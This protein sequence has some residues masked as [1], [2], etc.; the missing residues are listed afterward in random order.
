MTPKLIQMMVWA[1]SNLSSFS[2]ASEALERL[3]GLSI[4]DRRIRRQVESVGSARIAEREAAVEKMKSMSLPARREGRPHEECPDVAVVMMDGGRYQRRDHFGDA[5]LDEASQTHWRE[6]KIGCFLSMTSKVHDQDPCPNIPSEFAQASAV[7]EIA[8]IAEKTSDSEDH[9]ITL[10]SQAESTTTYEPPELLSKDVVASGQCAE[11]FGFHLEARAYALNF[12]QAKRTAFVADGLRVN[13]SI[14]EKH[15]PDSVAIADIIHVLSYVWSAA[16]AAEQT[17]GYSRWSQWIWQGDVHKVISELHQLSETYSRPEKDT[18]ATDPRWKIYRAL[19]YL[20]NNAHHMAYHLYRQKGLPLTSA[21][22]E[23]TV[24]QIN[25]RIKGTEKFW[26]QS[27]S[28]FVLQLRADS[29]S[30]SQP[31]DS[32]WRRWQAN[33]TGS[34]RYQV[35]C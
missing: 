19:T 13:W 31:L 14:Q 8:K 6:S 20:S 7:R 34:N 3:S 5:N 22:I 26:L 33:Q 21:H 1:G 9:E 4:S 23:S 17:D 32:F 35:A 11:Q 28:E 18:P 2:M 12:P 30:D 10:S 15:F 24:K 29:I 27:N 16:Q 25:R